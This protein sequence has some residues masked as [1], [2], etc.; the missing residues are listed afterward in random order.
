MD[1]FKIQEQ[2]IEIKMIYKKKRYAF[3]TLFIKV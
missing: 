2:K 1:T 3:S